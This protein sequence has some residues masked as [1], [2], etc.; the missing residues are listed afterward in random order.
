MRN[1]KE[2]IKTKASKKNI[3]LSILTGALA[4]IVNGL[5]GGGG[6]MLVVPMLS[7]LLKYESKKAHA[8]AILIILPISIV[9]GFLYYIFGNFN[10]VSGFPVIV[11]ALIGGG[12]GALLF[13]KLSTKWVVYIFCIIMAIAGIK[14]LFF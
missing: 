1:V 4:G 6:G 13:S 2:K 14:M 9:S 12:S 5:L 11:G 10:K 3:W 7:N 8:T